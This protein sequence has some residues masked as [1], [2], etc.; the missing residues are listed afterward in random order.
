M[1]QEN[2]VWGKER[3]AN[4]LGVRISPRTVRKSLP[5]RPPG[6]PRGDQRWSTFL[7]DHARAILAC[8]FAMVVTAHNRA[9][10]PLI[11]GAKACYKNKKYPEK[12]PRFLE[13]T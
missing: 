6:R 13:I 11:H 12:F 10:S 5:K 3:I 9:G 7:K 1:G 2:P 8:D 4:E